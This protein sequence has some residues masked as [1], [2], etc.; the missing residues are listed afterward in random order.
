MPVIPAFG[1]LRQGNSARLSYSARLCLKKPK[2]NRI[3]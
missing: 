1:R 3:K 2:I